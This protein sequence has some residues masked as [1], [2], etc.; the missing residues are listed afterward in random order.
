MIGE[1]VV[2]VQKAEVDLE[3]ILVAA[4]VAGRLERGKC[5]KQFALTVI[6][7][8]KFHSSLQKVSQ[9]IVG[10]VLQSINQEDFDYHDRLQDSQ[11]LQILQ[12]EVCGQ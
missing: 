5:T 7:N 12:K 2:S 6:M 9:Y 3:V 4:V 11:V 1:E 10:S 8:A